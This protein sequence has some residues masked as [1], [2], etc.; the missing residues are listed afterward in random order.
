[1]AKSKDVIVDPSSS[2]FVKQGVVVAVVLM[3]LG[4]LVFIFASAVTGGIIALLGV[5]MGM[6]SGLHL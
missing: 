1:M 5:I 3:V 6:G 4:L 2:T